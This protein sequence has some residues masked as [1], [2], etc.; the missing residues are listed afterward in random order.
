MFTDLVDSTALRSRLGD[1]AA[2]TIRRAHDAVLRT[3]V[4]THGGRLVKGLGD[5][6]MATFASAAEAVATA[7][8][9][10]QGIDVHNRRSAGERM[11]LRIGLSAGDVL[12]EG[13][14]CFG[15][16]VVEAARLCAEAGAG[17][18]LVSDVVRLLARSNDGKGFRACGPKALKGLDVP[19]ETH[20]LLWEPVPSM[21][22]VSGQPELPE[23]LARG[24]VL[25][26]TGRDEQVTAA[27][28]IWK[29]ALN[30]E[31]QALL[32]A[33]EPGIGKT[34]LAGEVSVLAHAQGATVLYG[35]C[36]ENLGAPYQPFAE[37]LDQLLTSVAAADLRQHLGRYPE[38]LTRLV[39][40]LTSLLPDLAP[41]LTSDAETERYR[42]FEAI[43]SWLCAAAAER[44]LVVVL[45]DLH[46]AARPTLTL[47]QHVLHA[48]AGARLLLIGTY[49]DTDLSRTHPLSALL[50]DLRRAPDVTR[51]ALTGLDLPGVVSMVTEA[52]GHELDDAG[53]ALAAAVHAETEG[54][55]FFIGE[56]LRHL[57]ES[58]AIYLEDGRWVSNLTVAQ[59]GIPEGIREVVG[60][61][62]DHL[63]PDANAV[64]PVAAI[65]G[66]DFTLDVLSRAAGVAEDVVVNG[67][68]EATRARLIE[69]TG[70]GCYRF[71]H[72]LV[73]S[74]LYEELSVTKRARMH[75][76]VATELE[77]AAPDDVVALA[78]HY[79]AAT[80]A[81]DL[82][83][84]AAYSSRAGD[85][86]M[87]QL[88]HDQAVVYYAQALELLGDA[89]DI[90]PATRTEMLL[91]LG[92][93]QRRSGDPEFRQTLLTA[94]RAARDSEDTERLV[95]A[96][97]ANGRGFWSMA[98][99]VDH[100]RMEVLQEALRRLGPA[101]S[102][103]RARLLA[104][105]GSE[106]MFTGAR[107]ER[108]RHSAEAVAVARR[109][110]DP[111][112]LA[113]VLAEAGPAN[114]TPWT[115]HL[116]ES[117][118]LE[119]LDLTPTLNDPYRL[120]VSHLWM[121]IV[122]VFAARDPAPGIASLAAADRIGQ[123]LGQ[124]TVRWLTLFWQAV[125]AQT[126]GRISE[127]LDLAERALVLGQ[128]TGQ[129]DA[130]T[131]YS[132]QLATLYRE[133]G[134]LQEL[135]A[136]I[137]QEVA[138]NPG[139]P[140]WHVVLAQALF[141]AGREEEA[142][143]IVRQLVDVEAGDVRLPEDVL[144]IFCIA[145]LADL[146]GKLAD[147]AV[148]ALLYAR[149]L[150]F[151][152][153]MVHGGVAF[154]G[155]AEH[156]LGVAAGALG[157]VDEGIAHLEQAIAAHEDL[158]ARFFLGLSYAEMARLLTMRGAEGDAERAASAVVSAR[159]LAEETSGGS[160]LSRLP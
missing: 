82:H 138:A 36:E 38:E 59:L 151:R 76:R 26:F 46:W 27:V 20:E 93:A 84:A 66:R 41:P 129:P 158:G 159:T 90:P 42:L 95:R 32:L 63:S 132:G 116:G 144:W 107:L 64:L 40:A 139:L 89:S 85:A 55:P 140:A 71:S 113:D 25:G 130:W 87:A 79:A 56:V 154:Y 61:R 69:E 134:R 8:A 119:L 115:I 143:G 57:R 2:D 88:A 74:T 155:S 142:H 97:L 34:R 51:I 45:D 157:R 13:E 124:P 75:A 37:A 12:W 49:R 44:G 43:A 31:R 153:L 4:D 7:I 19:L 114:Y 65:I 5:G 133:M 110:G 80:V 135:T 103:D 146:G 22:V 21:P 1:E 23:L 106:M 92:E 10:Q 17:Q 86:A 50:A 53:Q 102:P 121:Y 83:K 136:A 73:R 156:H 127:A 94:A 118:L 122:S 39:P 152:H 104:R 29:T 33:G 108:E 54:N 81:G 48:T 52:A 120:A 47:L 111:L 117:A 3:A 96:A 105:L 126:Q 100:E 68:D 147:R 72:A 14:D 30:G 98:G 24:G 18:I 60:R 35:R 16:P 148:V 58:R 145:A 78:H 109:V 137:E 15:R 125:Q 149:L 150:P 99:E 77:Q 123:E 131:W 141:E 128:A 70:V 62:L 9:V 67:L 101:D 160:I 112:A 91:S 6:G 28:Q 11:A